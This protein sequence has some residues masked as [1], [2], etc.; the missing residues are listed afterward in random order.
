MVAVELLCSCTPKASYL[1]VELRPFGIVIMKRH[2][3]CCP[4][5]FEEMPE[6]WQCCLITC[7]FKQQEKENMSKVGNSNI[8]NGG[9]R[10]MQCD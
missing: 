3:L 7:I 8:V 1:N 5:V 6:M 9:T 10:Q 4:V 2:A